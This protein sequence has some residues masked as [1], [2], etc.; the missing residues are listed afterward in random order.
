M[1]L[2][3]VA[4][5]MC[6]YVLWSQRHGPRT[7]GCGASQYF[8]SDSS[9]SLPV[10]VAVQGLI[11]MHEGARLVVNSEDTSGWGRY[12]PSRLAP[13]LGLYL[14]LSSPYLREGQVRTSACLLDARALTDPLTH[15]HPHACVGGG[16]SVLHVEVPVLMPA[17][18]DEVDHLRM[19]GGGGRAATSVAL[20]SLAAPAM[21]P[22]ARG[23]SV[24]SVDD[25][26]SNHAVRSVIFTRTRKHSQQ[27]LSPSPPLTRTHFVVVVFQIM[28]CVVRSGSWC[29]WWTLWRRRARWWCGYWNRKATTWWRCALSTF[30]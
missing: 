25:A 5:T 8:C 29:W 9:A 26:S 20:Q 28:L 1:A 2:F 10:V 22:V 6:V 30:N 11:S 15:P 4:V 19:L 24:V 14:S 18:A 27:W 12:A 7:T 23:A 13:Y 3:S 21:P 16:D 17:A